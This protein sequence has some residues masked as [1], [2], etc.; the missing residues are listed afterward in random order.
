MILEPQKV[1]APNSDDNLIPLINVVFLMLIFFMVA[2]HIESSDGT[3]VSP[4]LSSNKTES[5]KDKLKVVVTEKSE[6]F[7][8]GKSLSLEQLKVN[9]ADY[10]EQVPEGDARIELKADSQLTAAS[11]QGILLQIKSAGVNRISLVTESL[12]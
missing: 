11:L 1:T 3:Q 5:K 8:D 2:G 12:K 6:L 4:P 9:L 7:V 10:I